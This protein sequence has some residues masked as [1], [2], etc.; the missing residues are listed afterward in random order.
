MPSPSASVGSS[1]T[2]SLFA[3]DGAS[4]VV[5]TSKVPSPSLSRST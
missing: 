5:S 3:S 2:P 1:T 4:R